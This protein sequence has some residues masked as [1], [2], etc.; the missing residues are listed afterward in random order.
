VGGRPA[1]SCRYPLAHSD[2]RKQ[3]PAAKLL[4]PPN[5]GTA[6]AGN[7]GV[8]FGYRRYASYAAFKGNLTCG[9]RA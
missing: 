7:P 9:N 3:I 5:V 4:N 1:E 8:V 2:S 6:A